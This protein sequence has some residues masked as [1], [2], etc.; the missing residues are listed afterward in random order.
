MGEVLGLGAAASTFHRD[1]PLV[2]AV[3]ELDSMA[4]VGILTLVEDRFG[5]IV[6]D[7]EVDASVFETVGTLTDFVE[8]K[9]R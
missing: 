9:L 3:A 4:V 6:E 1:T 2:G 5:V 8:G 7:D